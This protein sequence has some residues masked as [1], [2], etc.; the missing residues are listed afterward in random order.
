[1]CTH[2]K[3]TLEKRQNEERAGKTFFYEDDSKNMTEDE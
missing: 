3:G 2:T 1:M